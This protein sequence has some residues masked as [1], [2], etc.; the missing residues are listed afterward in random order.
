MRSSPTACALLLLLS[1]GAANAQSDAQSKDPPSQSSKVDSTRALGEYDDYLHARITTWYEDC[2][3]GW[4]A[5]SHMSESDYERAC[6]RM[7]R[8]RVKFLGDEEK[9]RMRA[10]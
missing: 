10:K 4:N 5:T 9:R 7:A 1:S 8:D 6:L 2:L 3:K